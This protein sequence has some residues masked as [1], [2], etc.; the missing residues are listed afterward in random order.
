MSEWISL[1]GHLQSTALAVSAEPPNVQIFVSVSHSED[2]FK[3]G[4]SYESLCSTFSKI[5]KNCLVLWVKAKARSWKW[6]VPEAFP[7]HWIL[8]LCSEELQTVVL[9]VLLLSV[10]AR[11]HCVCSNTLFLYTHTHTHRAPIQLQYDCLESIS[12]MED[13]ISSSWFFRF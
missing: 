10:A 3:R 8:P 4:R 5:W 13:H 6:V 7:E 9:I 12:V 11:R 1:Y 2:C